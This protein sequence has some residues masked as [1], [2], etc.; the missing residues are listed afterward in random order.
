[1]TFCRV[2][3]QRLR[4]L[5]DVS[6]LAAITLPT[7]RGQASIDAARAARVCCEISPRLEFAPEPGCGVLLWGQPR[8]KRRDTHPDFTLLLHQPVK[9]HAAV[10]VRDI[11]LATVNHRGI[12]FIEQKLDA[13]SL[14][15]PKDLE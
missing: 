2:R 13:P 7:M 10:V 14:R 1:M 8:R 9:I 11:N 12:K 4:N 5:R 3:R 6:C 15:V